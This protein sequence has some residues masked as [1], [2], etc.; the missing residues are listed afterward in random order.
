M[1]ARVADVLLTVLSGLDGIFT[2]KANG[3]KGFLGGGQLVFILLGFGFLYKHFLWALHQRREI[4]TKNSG[5]VPS[6][7]LC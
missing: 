1:T 5:N 3:T 6:G 2:L 4:N 7:G